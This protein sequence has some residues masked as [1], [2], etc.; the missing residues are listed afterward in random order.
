V[1]VYAEAPWHVKGAEASPLVCSV[2]SRGRPACKSEIL[3]FTDMTLSHIAWVYILTNKTRTTLYVGF[4]TDLPTRL[5]EHRTKQNLDCYTARYNIS[6]LMFYQGFHSIESA[7]YRERMI[8]GKS[9]AWKH[10]LINKL[11]PKWVDL[12]HKI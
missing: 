6:E 10:A 11:N 3:I 2:L 7:E 4:T 12:T 8:K 1:I 5:W 9:R